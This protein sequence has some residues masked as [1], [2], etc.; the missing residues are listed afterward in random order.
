MEIAAVNSAVSVVV[1]GDADAVEEFAGQW[2]ER[3]RRVKRLM[4]SHA[5]HSPHM[6]GML[7]DFRSVAEG[8]EYR[9]P[10]VALVSNVT[11]GLADPVEVCSAEYWVRHVRGA[12]RFLD[13]V[14]ALRAEGVSVFLEL[15]PDGVLS[16]LGPDCLSP[17]DDEVAPVFAAALRGDDQQ[18]PGA[19]LEAVGRVHA[20]GTGVDWSAVLGAGPVAGDLPTYAFQRER[21]WLDV[22]ARRGDV[23]GL[24]LTAAGHPLLGAMVSLP[25]GRGTL[26]TG[27]LSLAEQPWL[28][29]HTL[30]GQVVLPPSVFVEFAFQAGDHV[31]CPHLE[32]LTCHLPLVLPS[33]AASAVAVQVL[34][35]AADEDGRSTVEIFSRPGGAADDAEWTLHASGTLAPTGRAGDGG[36]AFSGV[37]P[38]VWPP[39]GATPLRPEDAYEHLTRA[40]VGFG[41]AFRTVRAAWRRGEEV[42]AEVALPDAASGD[43]TGFG[44]RP[45]LLDAVL[46][47]AD[48]PTADDARLPSAWTGVELLGV[49]AS[50]ARIHVAHDGDGLS[51]EVADESGAPVLSVDR[52][53]TRPVERDQLR[54]AAGG[55]LVDALF[56]VV[57]EPVTSVLN[58]PVEWVD[59]GSSEAAGVVLWVVDGDRASGV[60]QV[61]VGALS[62]VREFVSAERFAGSR[63]VVLTRGAAGEAV[64]DV[65][66]ASV[67]GLVRSA[68]REHPDRL[69]LVDV[70]PGLSV[71][72]EEAALRVALGAGESQVAVR[73][74]RAFVPRL[75]RVG[76][77]SRGRGEFASGGTVLVTGGTGG[78]GA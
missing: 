23:S 59:W 54:A 17:E 24:G 13:G 56:D 26:W 70:E 45:G 58:S 57:W 41:P 29:D 72:A 7:D 37:R 69:V 19:L 76:E 31:K 1:S 28:A 35:S 18:G 14:R 47:M 51:V 60:S 74:G 5:F 73:D 66:A 22:P 63:L 49:G 27:R 64:V 78:L 32:G 53:V 9:A 3:G 38:Q 30:Y 65:S 2:K 43:T 62:V 44:L 34:V 16:A 42:F 75:A 36:D 68:Q 20:C 48:D 40:Q 10:E 21:F 55:G 77:V 67:W 71:E 12:V 39:A 46:H 25:D 4:V 33:D 11:G 15:G 50:V 52:L 61:A 6:D 8:L